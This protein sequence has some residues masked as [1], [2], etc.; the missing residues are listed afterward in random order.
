MMGW[1]GDGVSWAHVLGMSVFWLILIGLVVLLVVQLLPGND[2]GATRST[3][4]PAL[5]ILDRR[6]AVG[7]I[8]VDGWRAQRAALLTAPSDRR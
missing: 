2:A 6:L 8:D 4:D 3:G 7:E 5:E 1:Y